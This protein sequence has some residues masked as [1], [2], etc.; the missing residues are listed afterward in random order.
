MAQSKF[1]K[2]SKNMSVLRRLVNFIL[3]FFLVTGGF[4]LFYSQKE[5]LDQLEQKRAAVFSLIEAQEIIEDQYQWQI[6]TQEGLRIFIDPSQDIKKQIDLVK[7]VLLELKEK[8]LEYIGVD[9]KGQ[10]YYRIK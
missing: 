3:I 1:Q 4:F 2:H 7:Q 5:T 6:I 10:V 8:N 9:A